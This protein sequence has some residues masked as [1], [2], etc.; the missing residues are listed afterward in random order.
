MKNNQLF[1]PRSSAFALEPRVL[2][3]GAAAVAVEDHLSAGDPLVHQTDATE[4]RTTTAVD[5]TT[6]NPAPAAAP[7]TLLVVDSRVADYQSL[8]G[9]LPG[10]VMVRVINADES[11]LAALDAAINNSSNI[12]SIQIISHGSSGSISLGSD[13]ITSSTLSSSTQIQGWAPHLTDDADIL[14]YGCDVGSGSNGTTFLSQLATLTGADIAASTNATGSAARGGDWVLE[15]QTG[16]IDSR[17]AVGEAAL[18]R[19]DGLFAA[20]A[21]G[22]TV[23][24]QTVNDNTPIT[25]FATVTI[26]DADPADIQRLSVALDAAAKGSLSNLSGGLYD[27]GTGLYTFTGSAAAAQAAI[28]GL[29]FTPTAN[30]VAPGTT[31]T[32]TFTISVYDYTS[33]VT[34]H[35]STVIATSINDAPVAV[36]DTVSI[37]EDLVSVAGNILTNDTDVDTGDSKTVTDLTGGTVGNVLTSTHGSL[38]L[39]VDGSYIYTLDNDSSAVQALGVG[40]SLTETFHYTM[41]DAANATSAS[42]LTVTINGTND[43]PQAVADTVSIAEDQASV[44]GNIVINDTDVDTGDAKTVST[45]AGGT[46]GS[47]LTTA[48]GSL[49]LNV[50]GSYTY[51]LDNGNTL[52]QELGI[53]QILV[54]TFTYTMKDT[55]N[56]TSSS[57][58][59]VTINGTNDQ[60]VLTPSGIS[61]AQTEDLTTAFTVTNLLTNA[62]AK[63]MWSDTDAGTAMGI[64]ITSASG[65]DAASSMTGTWEYQLSGNAWTP[66]PVVSAE[67]ALLLPGD[68]QVR[69]VVT[70]NSQIDSRN[71]G[72]VSLSYKAWDASSG[73]AGATGSTTVL[74]STSPFSSA[75]NTATLNVTPVNDPP[76]FTAS[77]LVVNEHASVMLTGGFTNDSTQVAGLTGNMRIYDPDNSTTQILY[78]IE[79]LPANGTLN[80][81][82]AVLGV[83]S[84]FSQSNISSITYTPTVGELTADTTDRFY[85]TIRDGAGGIIGSDGKNTGSNPWAFL[86]ISIKDV[87]AQVAVSGTTLVIAEDNANPGV[88][89]IAP[90]PLSMVDADDPD[91]LRTLTITSLPGA[92]FGTLQYWNG[93]SYQ[94]ATSGLGF[95][96]AQLTDAVHPA[97]RFAYNNSTEPTDQ[98]GT[99]ISAESQ[100]SF[101]VSISDNNGHLAPTTA[102]A[103]V[104]ITIT[105]INDAPLLVTSGLT[106]GQGSSNNN[107]GSTNLTTTDPDS[108]ANLR[109]YT[110]SVDPARGYL[111]LNGVRIG[112]GS[113]FSESDLSSGVLK[114]TC[115]DAYY[116]GSDSLQV[117]ATDGHGADSG[118]KT[119][120]IT[121]TADNS[122][123]LPVFSG[124]IGS[125]TA[126]I[127]GTLKG[128]S[129][130]GLFLTLDQRMLSDD[131]TG[132]SFTFTAPVHGKVYLNGVEL[133]YG[134]AGT[135]FTQADINSG[136]IIYIHDSSEGSAY[137]FTDTLNITAA[138]GAAAISHSF[139]ITIS[140]V[141]DAP[142]ISQTNAGPISTN[143]DGGMLMEQHVDNSN[144]MAAANFALTGIVNAVNIVNAVKLTTDNFQWHDIDNTQSQLTYMVSTVGGT[145]GRWNGSAWGA[146]TSFSADD[147]AAGNI[148][149]FHNPAADVA[150][151]DNTTMTGSVT[152]YLIDGGVVA[153][154]DV[155]IAP[156]NISE[157]NTLA[158][159]DGTTS[160]SLIKDSQMR[161]PD[162]TVTFTIADVNDAPVASNTS[163]TA[164]EFSSGIPGQTNHI[165]VLTTALVAASDSDTG[166]ATWTYTLTE[167]PTNGTI[168]QWDGSAWNVMTVN[169]TFTYA[170]LNAGSLRYVNAGRIEVTSGYDWNIAHDGFKF[171]VND[172]ELI[173]SPRPL[174]SNE[175]TV[176][177]FLRP[178]NQPPLAVNNGPGSV[179]E[180]GALK[181]TSNLLG[182]ADVANSADIVKAI[183]PDNSRLQVQYRITDNV[184]HGFLYLG[185]PATG[186]ITKQLS[187]GS[188]FTLE[189]IQSGR[190]WYQHNGTEAALYSSRDTFTYAISDASGMTE[191]TAIFVINIKPVNDAPVVTGLAGGAT[192]TEGDSTSSPN[193]SPVLIDT[194][195]TLSDSDLANNSA[196]FRGGSLT[197]SDTFGNKTSDQLSI[198]NIGTG[199][200]QIGYD[201]FTGIV[202]CGGVQIGTVTTGGF[203]N[204]V[205]GND[206]TI[207][208]TAGANTSLT[209]PAVKA[210]I[211]AITFSHTEYDKAITGTRTLNYVLIDGGGTSDPADPLYTDSKNVYF[212]GAD[213]WSGSATVTVAAANDR[214][215]LTDYDA[216]SA[217]SLGSPI[218]E[219]NTNPAGYLVSGFLTSSA[220][221]STH[222]GITDADTGAEQGIAVTSV[223]NASTG[224]WEYS[225]D[226]STNWT[227][228]GVVS[229]TSALLLAPAYSVRFVPD[230][231]DGGTATFTYKAWDRTSGTA[232][233]KTS[234]TSAA[235]TSAFSSGTDSVKM[236]VTPLNDAPT[237]TGVAGGFV[238]AVE[239]TVFNFTGT[240]RITLDDVDSGSGLIKLTLSFAGSGS[241]GFSSETGSV[242]TDAGGTAPQAAWSGFT[243]GQMLTLYGTRTNLDAVVGKL[244]Y[245]PAADANNFNL[246]HQS[247]T[248]QPSVRLDVDDLGYG[249]NSTPGSPLTATRTVAVNITAVNDSP[250]VTLDNTPISLSENAA[251]TTVSNDI[252]L[253]DTKDI[254]DTNYATAGT[255]LPYLVVTTHNGFLNFAGAD[256]VTIVSGEGSGT[257]TL[258]GTLVD[259]SAALS[260]GNHSLSY[261]PYNNFSG[262]DTVTLTLHDNGNGGSGGDKTDVKNIAITVDG[263]NE[264]PSFS[265]LGGGTPDHVYTEKGAAIVLDANATV[266][267][268]EL[269]VYDNWGNAVLTLVRNGGAQSEDVFGVTGSGNTGVNFSGAD[270][271][272]IGITTVGSF[273]NESGQLRI[274]FANG[275]ATVQVNQVLQAITYVNTSNDPAADI[276]INYTIDDGNTNSGINPQGTST[277][278]HLNNAGSVGIG[279]TAVN[280]APIFTMTSGNA[281]FTENALTPII[282]DSAL[283]LADYDDTQLTGA[284]VSISGNFVNGD[285]LAVAGTGLENTVAGTSIRVDSYDSVT[286][287]LSLSGTDTVA[288]YQAV[289]RTVTFTTPSDDPT[290]NTTAGT[291]IITFAA[292][293][294]NSR[295]GG[296]GA[297][298]GAAT[299]A[300]AVTPTQDAPILAGGG[301][302]LAYTENGPAAVI[303][304]TV[305]VLSDDDDTQMGGA[306]ISISAGYTTGDTLSFTAQNG[307]S[308]LSNSGAVLTLT[309]KATLAQYTAALQSVQYSSTSDDPTVISASRTVTWR[310]TDANSDNA[311]AAVSNTCIS[312]INITPV[313]DG[314]TLTGSAPA[315]IYTE[316]TSGVVLD[317]NITVSDVDDTQ[318][319]SATVSITSNLT[320]GDTL[321]FTPQNGISILSNAGGVLT[322]TGTATLAHYTTAL[323]SITFS[324]TSDDP[325]VNATR[326]TRAIE[327]TVTDA[328]SD[329]AGA[330]TSASRTTALTVIPAQDA[331]ILGGGGQTLLYTE[332]GPAAAIDATINVVSDADDIQMGGA[333]VR[334][335]AG[336]TLG[337]TLT[338]TP[339]NGIS[340]AS[341]ANGVLT[342]TGNAPFTEYTAALQSVQY[343]SS[344][345][346]PTAISTSRTV[347]WQVTDANS[348]LAGAASSNIVLS[349]IS[350]TAVN[351]PPIANPDIGSAVEAGGL[352]NGTAGS[353]ATGNVLTNDTD[354]DS[355]D[356]KTV[357]T[358]G[359][360]I[361]TYGTL[362]LNANGSY[363][364]VVNNSNAA[365]QALRITGQKVSEFFDYTMRD[366]AG[367]TS[368]STLTINIDGRND[369]PVGVNDTAT[370][371]EASGIANVTVGVNPTGNVLDNDTDV[372]AVVNGETKTVNGARIGTEAAGG[373]LTAVSAG[374]TSVTGLHLVGSYGTLN[375][376]SN[377][378]YSY[379]VDNANTMVQS[380]RETGQSVTDIFTYRVRDTG[381]LSDTAQLTVTIDG[382][383]DNPVAVADTATAVEAG[384]LGNA[385]P[386]TDPTG[387][388]LINDTD[389]DS[390]A[391]GETKTVTQVT[392]ATAGVVGGSTAGAHGTLHLNG[393]GSYTYNVNNND[394]TVQA[395]RTSGDT[396]T[397]TFNYTMKD[398][399][400]LTSSTQL[401]VTI[402]GRNDNPVAVADTATAVEAGGLG[403][404]APGTDPTGNVLTND[405]D[406][407]SVANG[408]TKTVTQVSGAAAGVV[409]GSTSG[410]HGTL[411]LN[412]DGSYTYNVN[413]ND[414][415]VQSLRT[416]GDTLTDTFNYTM[417]DA[418]GLTSSTTLIVTI[419]GTNDGPVAVA[420]TGAVI[421]DA[422][423][424][425]NAAAGVLQNDID[426]DVTDSKTVTQ[427]AQGST[428]QAVTSSTPGVI[429]SDYGT[430]TLNIDGSYSYVADGSASKAIFPGHIATD[431]FTYTMRDTNGLTSSTSLT[432][433]ITGSNEA[434]VAVADTGVALEAGGINNGTPGSNA[435]GNVLD[436][437]TDVDV[438]DTKTVV[439]VTGVG[440][441]A[442]DGVTPGVHG[443]LSLHANGTYIY[444]VDNNDAAVQALR[445]NGETL[446]DTFTYTMRDTMGATSSTSLTVVIHGANDAPVAVDDTGHLPEGR[447][448]TVAILGNDNDP[449][450]DTLTVSRIAGISL[451]PGGTVII[452]E[453]VVMLNTDG[454]LTYTPNAGV[455]GNV[456]FSYEISDGNGGTATA[457]VSISVV[458]EP[459]IIP[460]GPKPQFF[461]DNRVK[462]SGDQSVFFFGDSYSS[463]IRQVIPFSP[464]VF[465]HQAVE[466]A[467]QERM[468]GDALSFSNPDMVRLGNIESQSIGAELGLDPVLF[469]QHAVRDSQAQGEFIDNIVNGRLTRI[470]LSSD[471]LIPTPDLHQ[472][473]PLKIMPPW[474]IVE[475]NDIYEHDV[476]PDNHLKSTLPVNRSKDGTTHDKSWTAPS[477]SEQIRAAGVS[478]P[479]ADRGTFHQHSNL[480]I[481]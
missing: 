294:S 427:A 108:P 201:T 159:N 369:T 27:A 296:S 323:R 339:Q 129:P 40:Q 98:N 355:H 126:S 384:G 277:P 393:D 50:D 173:S 371:V 9:D 262:I 315:P 469:V 470:S 207:N 18:A 247:S 383:N 418:A 130:E 139:T 283:S 232:G 440:A 134:A 274:T 442:V 125:D 17:L 432:I 332:V 96:Q 132:S 168:Q 86:D 197:I 169:T 367:L 455:R 196:D 141:D 474:K 316:N 272:R 93:S 271:L 14:L 227:S 437:D 417:K 113:T 475:I 336:Y 190:L 397:D 28:R 212:A 5:A 287:V 463:V 155:L 265:G 34:D 353:N 65:T 63:A 331:P 16:P 102:N 434:P 192:F 436:N 33:T 376:G 372:D 396:L 456:V 226:G 45:L 324:S 167:L 206:L 143:Q 312:N 468:N 347:A 176:S 29:V 164:T 162:R 103:A 161:S 399:A 471:R 121:I 76:A 3:D 301:Q 15:L 375:I 95:T 389:V 476:L 53:G 120:A 32:T 194:S 117:V 354:V 37:A 457:E 276:T 91:G 110:V 84:L 150:A 321:N 433:T 148:A 466:L 391:N 340:I 214:P 381:G 451:S 360:R 422:T 151:P 7:T 254:F 185:D 341:N 171:K 259:L 292:T 282:I 145:I 379:V 382:R 30:H 239:D 298:T 478:G 351:D 415:A 39:N 204:G 322:L 431:T 12:Q 73:L 85:F 263:A 398:A 70:A 258:Q 146:V 231:K 373:T 345:H 314:P 363:T 115:N 243:D 275:A 439:G 94:A 425:V 273:T 111:T 198:K 289:L 107:I 217:I 261:T 230:T 286:G 337:D 75:A 299:R 81:N 251:A 349:T 392:G 47:A 329:G 319:V 454:T 403:N 477:F 414:S 92:T 153:A 285:V 174:D 20:P 411:H 215:V 253:T 241:F 19:Y 404:A 421:H 430:L 109:T 1:R 156:P 154:G 441:G 140:P 223:S 225:A 44:A 386:G 423:L 170:E 106:V 402:D 278:L 435:M 304:S 461:S 43:A 284:R 49:L 394:A 330:H 41:R 416:S 157:K 308:I 452:P 71:S 270:A 209:V 152:V 66:F 236:V 358:T 460:A 293:D 334:I 199:P 325:T 51:T 220:A 264:A 11:G 118:V 193:I 344:S 242:Y 408:E 297:L 200:G 203:A 412:G 426:V 306:T 83:G 279:I 8:L 56:E 364:Y 80:L 4:V 350:I 445:N 269:S 2:F 348:D 400:G 368:S 21:I 31:E 462:L 181:I 467:Q 160:L 362:T 302:T 187:V 100:T 6:A 419:Q 87:N 401:T 234:T 310:V 361:G 246:A 335:S 131:G 67:S 346:D 326:T 479:I 89:V 318:I 410:A 138:K 23:T 311:G 288:N 127:T 291:R 54:E 377:G 205:N 60:P 97:L 388:V 59:T 58:L 260:S 480:K 305:N 295:G 177:I 147:L 233:S 307:I 119:L 448:V 359:S 124:T 136:R 395:L 249:E 343:S 280:D 352:N 309:G 257:L 237:L 26:T 365:V 90:I 406:V 135:A 266:T 240:N 338:F 78:R 149:Y 313:N 182:S 69:F 290:A 166:N 128:V 133:V 374:T 244:Q 137:A 407:D 429:L 385:A 267:D 163:F 357:T 300:I 175:A 38:L 202:T 229:D 55:A 268:P 366:P 99:V 79:E 48:Y 424:S 68:A 473:N 447:P 459:N 82:G 116:H 235:Q 356:T 248:A 114:Y 387:N 179:P 88:P 61:L 142:T 413:N 228:F 443:T 195:V 42:T 13:T 250:S 370:A 208:F 22:G 238:N 281:A 465:I 180:G 221:D 444:N 216:G 210:L 458:P 57:T 178:T 74:S 222:S 333:T 438:G 453:G 186:A 158:V 25:P 165:Q 390:A 183:D 101:N 104:N 188:A 52:V 256:G 64:A 464:A 405:T 219:D 189:D 112:R 472:P 105:P 36:A 252:V 420:D 428:T 10:N 123:P 481:Y 213:I 409:G 380:L 327:W 320:S 218:D 191:P 35:S 72:T 184:D 342:L 317:G 77:P 378:T 245:T 449:E 446:T 172:G 328:D 224:H 62:S 144:G 122:V 46:I 211:E 303:D 450:S 24:S 255:S